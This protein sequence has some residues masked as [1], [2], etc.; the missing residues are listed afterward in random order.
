MGFVLIDRG[1]F[2]EASAKGQSRSNVA[3]TPYRNLIDPEAE[4]FLWLLSLV[5]SLLYAVYLGNLMRS[6]T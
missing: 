3:P 5:T 2:W 6:T 1:L 4:S